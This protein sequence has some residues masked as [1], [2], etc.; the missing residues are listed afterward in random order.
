[1]HKGKAEYLLRASIL[2]TPTKGAEG[3]LLARIGVLGQV[4]SEDGEAIDNRSRDT[5]DNEKD[6]C[7]E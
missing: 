1:M 4:D 3:D 5:G 6:C 7:Y 2:N